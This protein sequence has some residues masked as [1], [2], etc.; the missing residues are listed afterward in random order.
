[1]KKINFL[2]VLIISILL[3]SCWIFGHH[4]A[5]IDSLKNLLEKVKG[6]EKVKVLNYLSYEYQSTSLQKSIE[7][8]KQALEILHKIGDLKGESDILNNMGISYYSLSDYT[9]ALEYF[10]KSL[11]LKEKIGD[12]QLIVKSLNN[13]GVV[14]QTLGNYE[15][16]IKYLQNSL[17]LKKELN[18]TIG[19]AKSL[20]NIGAIYKNLGNYTES[21]ELTQEALDIYQKIND[22]DGIATAYNNLGIVFDNLNNKY[23]ALEYYNKSLEIKIQLDDK[24]GIANTYNNIGIIYKEQDNFKK[25]L[26]YFQKSLKIREEINDKFGIAS[27]LDNIGSLYM[28]SGNYLLALE[29]LERSLEISQKEKLID[30]QKRVLEN[31]SETYAALGEFD[32]VYI[33]YK[34][35]SVIKDSIFNKNTNKMITELQVKYDTQKKE[36][37]NKL[38]RKNIELHKLKINYQKY[39][40]III[41]VLALILIFLLYNNY[42]IRKKANKEFVKKNAEITEQKK[43]LE[44]TLVE[45]KSSEDENIAILKVFPDI[46]FVFDKD[47]KFLSY[48]IKDEKELFV[49]P[50]KFLGKTAFEILPKEI[51][52]QIMGAIENASQTGEL[53]TFEYQIAINNEIRDYEVRLVPTENLE[54][55]AMIRDVTERNRMEEQLEEAKNQAEDTSQQKSMF[56]ANMSHEIRTPLSSIIGITSVLEETDL[57]DE[58]KEYLNVISI[59]G[60][61]LLNLINNILDFS[62]IESGQI[63]LENVDFSI[64]NIID[65]I[66]LIMKLKA[67]EAGISLLDD[68]ATSVPEL[69]KGDPGRLKQIVIN[70]TNNAIK[71]TKEGS[72][73]IKIE[74]LTEDKKTIQLKFSIIDTGIGVSVDVRDRLFKAFSQAD[75]SISR[76]YGGTGLGLVIS[77][78]LAELMG[79][80]VGIESEKGKGSIFWFTI[81][82]AKHKQLSDKELKEIFK[83]KSDKKTEET[84]EHLS[85]LL[86]EDNFLNQKFAEA[87][88]MKKN[89]KV[90][91]AMNGK[92][93]VEMFKKNKYDAILMDIQMPVM[94]GIEAT[95]EIRKYEGE[96]NLK[97]IKIIA[98][99]AYAMP[100]D[101][102][103]FYKAGI[104]EYIKKPYKSNELLNLIKKS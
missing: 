2:S 80:E 50:H 38:L 35:Y 71:F 40:I 90:D 17:E 103:K 101:Q 55:L 61:N 86:V 78:R 95:K 21:F 18:D 75:P 97:R 4:T 14:Y 9:N 39:I 43:L 32:K 91:I 59:S 66:I 20:I 79:G 54:F 85:I 57:T 8:D 65:E 56:L 58:Q 28:Q 31:L 87:I 72:V 22:K 51:S 19:I 46:I 42:S 5:K 84:K 45:L 30:I 24:K 74:T 63:E 60:S 93:G 23:L 94:D 7:Y 1:M 52:D 27:S 36:N 69:V 53:Q 29:L 25:A 15:E 82:F 33:Y 34:K 99:T 98:I 26:D 11:N 70:L 3:N 47:G 104:D 81:V 92:I 89:Y 44:K 77:K 68:I 49:P 10:K 88:L 67:E 37:E 13:L 6:K 83:E 100:G 73:K 64:R 76:E 16:A 48:N 62:K 41:I 96:N 12:N 102:E